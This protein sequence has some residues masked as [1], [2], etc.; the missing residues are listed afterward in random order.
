MYNKSF[1]LDPSDVELI[2]ICLRKE[3]SRIAISRQ[4]VID[5]TIVPPDQIKSLKEYDENIKCINT[6][7]G[8]LHEQKNWYRP[9]DKVYV[10]G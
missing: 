8:R 4:T 10:S 3:Q 2:E 9:K 5:S 6:L 7:L 1:K